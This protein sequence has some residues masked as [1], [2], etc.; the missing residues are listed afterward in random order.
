MLCTYNGYFSHRYQEDRRKFVSWTMHAHDLRAD[1]PQRI[2]PCGWFR[3]SYKFISLFAT[4]VLH[5][6]SVSYTNQMMYT[7][8][9]CC[10]CYIK[11][12]FMIR[13][14]CYDLNFSICKDI[15]WVSITYLLFLGKWTIT[16]KLVRSPQT[17]I[18]C[19]RIVNPIFI[20]RKLC[21]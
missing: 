16:S 5:V 18:L 17:V 7:Y 12:S 10:N 15:F 14:N 6:S 4:K 8:D 1:R 2:N 21:V 11:L 19:R 13:R 20:K 9:K 3:H